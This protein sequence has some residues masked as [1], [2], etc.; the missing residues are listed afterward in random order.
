[1]YIN[2]NELIQRLVALTGKSRFNFSPKTV[3][4]LLELYESYASKM[5][6]IYIDVPNKNKS[7]V[8][9]LGAIYDSEKKMWLIPP[10][11]DLSNF[12]SWM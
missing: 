1:M 6:Q 5:E 8:R 2:K 7:L 12:N 4:E 9:Q 3:K 10:G 11:V